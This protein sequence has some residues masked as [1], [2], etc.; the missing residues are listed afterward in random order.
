M[1]TVM[2]ERLPVGTLFRVISEPPAIHSFSHNDIFIKVKKK[3]KYGAFNIT[4]NP[5]YFNGT[6][7]WDFVPVYPDCENWECEKIEDYYTKPIQKIEPIP[8]TP[9]KKRFNC[10]LGNSDWDMENNAHLSLT[11]DQIQ[12]LEYLINET[13]TFDEDVGLMVIDTEEFKAF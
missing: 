13:S 5:N 12:L 7:N 9:T 11:S 4:V 6:I 3:G 10:I 2:F 1:N 8:T